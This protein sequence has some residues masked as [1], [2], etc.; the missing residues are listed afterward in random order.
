[1]AKALRRLEDL[2]M[3]NS[4]YC[5]KMYNLSEMQEIIVNI[6]KSEFGKYPRR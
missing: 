2:K 5:Q 3:S 1:M 4:L 6:N